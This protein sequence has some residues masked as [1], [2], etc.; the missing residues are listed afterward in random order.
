VGRTTG[1][2]FGTVV[3]TC[4][5][6]NVSGSDDTQLCQT[7][8]RGGAGGGDSGSPV[9]YRI[10]A[11]AKVKLAGILWGGGFHPAFGETYI[12]SPLDNIEEDL[13][14]LKVN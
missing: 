8:V 5:D 1:W 9:F 12:F 10:G 7:R 2:T 3:S 11:G 14:P 4:A 13:G 6:I